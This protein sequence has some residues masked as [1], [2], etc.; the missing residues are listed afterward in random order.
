MVASPPGD[1]SRSRR[2]VRIRQRKLSIAK[3]CL[4]NLKMK[5]ESH[6]RWLKVV[7]AFIAV[8]AGVSAVACTSA[9]KGEED[10]CATYCSNLP[11]VCPSLGKEELDPAL[12]KKECLKDSESPRKTCYRHGTCQRA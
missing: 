10:E 8:G 9:I 5:S 11:S 2:N 12:C 3:Y 1:W 4:E 7:A 6:M